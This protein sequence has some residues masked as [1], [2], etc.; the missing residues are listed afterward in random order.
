MIAELAPMALAAG[1]GEYD[2][3]QFASAACADSGR[4]PVF[5][6]TGRV[7]VGGLPGTREPA[8]LLYLLPPVRLITAHSDRGPAA[9]ARLAAEL[10]EIE[11][12]ATAT[13]ARR[14]GV[15]SALL[16]TAHALAADDGVRV[17]LAKT[18]AHDFPVP[19]WW[20]HRGYTLAR[21]GQNVRLHLKPSPSPATTGTTATGWPCAP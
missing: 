17:L 19:R 10:R 9:Q 7:L 18:A 16:H 20:R 6:G 8:G 14:A 15:G 11:L 1:E 12:V 5:H 13:H 3:S 2:A 4:I 21:P